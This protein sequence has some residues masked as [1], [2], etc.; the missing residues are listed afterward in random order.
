MMILPHCRKAQFVVSPLID[1][2][3]VTAGTKVVHA[4]AATLVGVVGAAV[5]TASFSLPTLLRTLSS[6]VV[7]CSSAM[8]TGPLRAC[9]WA[10]IWAIRESMAIGDGLR[11]AI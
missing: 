8:L 2:V 10:R 7:I 5:L 1:I 3:L 6:A 9:P 11:S 4:G